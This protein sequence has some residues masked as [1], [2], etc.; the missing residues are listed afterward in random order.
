MT[1]NNLPSEIQGPLVSVIVPVYNSA[2]TLGECLKSVLQQ[3]YNRWELIIVDSDSKDDSKRIATR[4]RSMHPDRIWFYNISSRFQ[5]AK[6][7]FAVTH[8]HGDRIFL[9]DSDQYLSP[10]VLEVCADPS[11]REWDALGVPVRFVVPRGYIQKSVFYSLT[12]PS[13][14]TTDFPN[15]IRRNRWVELGGL[16]ESLDY[17]EDLDFFIKFKR[18]GCKMKTISSAFSIHDQENSPTSMLR[19]TFNHNRGMQKLV[20]KWSNDL[21]TQPRWHR[22]MTAVSEATIHHPIY[23]PGILCA[24]L[25]RLLALFMCRST[26]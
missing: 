16:D 26:I 23:S 24:L 21:E 11:N 8:S 17:V 19:K 25:V 10:N 5:A 22:K 18:A 4:F 7:N 2:R 6:R 1:A 13:T 14:H 12:D 20:H 9:H 15:F 3:T